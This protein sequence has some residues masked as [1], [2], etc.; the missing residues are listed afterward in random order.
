MTYRS[1]HLNIANYKLM[2]FSGG[3]DEFSSKAT[4]SWNNAVGYDNKGNI[5]NL[6]RIAKQFRN[7]SAPE[8]MFH[9]IYNNYL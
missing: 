1:V 9:R 5:T 7:H 2:L 4:S 8:S 3:K 6:H